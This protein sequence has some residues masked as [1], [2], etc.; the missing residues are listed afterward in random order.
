MRDLNE[1]ENTLLRQLEEVTRAH[2]LN[3]EHEFTGQEK[4]QLSIS[5]TMNLLI[6]AIWNSCHD[7]EGQLEILHMVTETVKKGLNDM[8]INS[9]ML[10]D[11]PQ[12]NP[13]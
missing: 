7:P 11:M 3:P 5:V 8:N 6:F 12:I 10:K 9:Q 13:N 2:I 1:H 4:C